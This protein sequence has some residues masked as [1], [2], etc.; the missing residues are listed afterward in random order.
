MTTKSEILQLS[1]DKFRWKTEGKID[2][3]ADLF[4]DKLVFIHTPG[5]LPPKPNGSGN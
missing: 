2:L 3:I 5:R 1:L 4:D